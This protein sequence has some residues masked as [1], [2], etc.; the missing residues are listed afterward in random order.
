M[1]TFML[2]AVFLYLDER[3]IWSGIFVALSAQCK[4][5]GCLI[6]F[7]LFM[8]WLIYRRDKPVDYISSLLASA[9]SF[10][11]FT[12]LFNFFITGVFG[13]PITQIDA[14][15][16]G[17]VANKFTDPKLI[18]SSRPWEWLYPMWVR[19]VETAPVIVYC[20]D[21]Q[22]FSFISPTI[23]LLIIPTIGY[24][25]YKTIRGSHAAGLVLLWFMATYLFWIPMVLL[26][27]RVTF[28]FYFLATTPAICIGISMALSDILYLLQYRRWKFDRLT[29]GVTITYGVIALYLVLHFATF[30]VFN[31]VVPPV[32]AN[33]IR[34]WLPQS[35]LSGL[36]P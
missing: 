29:P 16:S 12:A 35:A 15:L 28:V 6:I 34:E 8:H 9:I 1:V 24:M 23:Q 7:A 11:V 3:Y 22:Y 25:I 4:L 36:I 32:V 33:I 10:V 21:P 26:T 14:M 27:N 18:I 17:T 31:P 19:P 30:M 13:N 2:A 20:Y 5:V